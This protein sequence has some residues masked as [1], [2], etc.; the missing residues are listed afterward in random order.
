MTTKFI[1]FRAIRVVQRMSIAPFGTP[2]S[3]VSQDVV[4]L[5]TG[6]DFDHFFG[7]AVLFNKMP[8]NSNMV[9]QARRNCSTYQE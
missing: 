4:H 6:Q 9:V 2:L 7:R 1:V 8:N 5:E 3:Q